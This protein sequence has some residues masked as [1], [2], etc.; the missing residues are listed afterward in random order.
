[1]VPDGSVNAVAY[2]DDDTQTYWYTDANGKNFYWDEEAKEYKPEPDDHHEAVLEMKKKLKVEA[3]VGED[4]FTPCD[5]TLL[6][7]IAFEMCVDIAL[8]NKLQTGI[9]TYAY[10]RA[11]GGMLKP[12]VIHYR[13]DKGKVY[14]VRK[15]RSQY[16]HISHFGEIDTSSHTLHELTVD[17]LTKESPLEGQAFVI[18]YTNDAYHEATKKKKPFRMPKALKKALKKPKNHQK[19]LL[20]VFEEFQDRDDLLEVMSRGALR[21]DVKIDRVK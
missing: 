7:Q 17:P 21:F 11:N 16:L 3:F 19:S 8:L 1:V 20:F 15:N 10:V 5:P 12:L 9:K 2:W 13:A 18:F 14:I 6:R 4:K